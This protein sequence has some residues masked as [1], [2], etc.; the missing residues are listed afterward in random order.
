MKKLLVELFK[1]MRT[2]TVQDS[3][4]QSHGHEISTANNTTE[5]GVP[6]PVT[7]STNIPERPIYL[8]RTPQ[9]KYFQIDNGSRKIAYTVSG[10][11]KAT[12][13]LLCLPGLLETKN[14]FLTIHAHFLPIEKYEVISVDLT[15]R[16]DSD[17]L[18]GRDD[19]RMSVYLADL[20]QLI[21]AVIL[22]PA[23]GQKKVTI[24]GTSMGGVLA[25]YL[26]QYFGKSIDEIILNDIALTVNWTS[27][28]A[29]Y[30]AMKNETSFKGLRELASDL[31]VHEHAISGVQQPSHFDLPYKADVW[32]MNFHQALDDYRGKIALIYGDQSKICTKQRILEAKAYIP[33]LE[34][35]AVAGA[36]H[37]APLN[38]AV[39]NFIQNRMELR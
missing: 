26:T 25:M 32:G 36:G 20:V 15:G 31:R 30:K 5:L 2:E 9:T 10:D 28:Y 24:L 33:R 22:S 35:Y 18:D 8:P 34:T 17:S 14:S 23:E 11:E 39:C 1:R 13:T 6:A 16:G 4:R 29:L 38:E 3:Q 27:L 19:Y 7:V 12:K 21:S 37:P